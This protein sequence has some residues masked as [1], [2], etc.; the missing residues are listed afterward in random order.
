MNAALDGLLA[1]KVVETRSY[2]Q[3][4]LGLVC[5]ELHTASGRIV[6]VRSKDVPT[7]SFEAYTLEAA[8]GIC[9]GKDLDPN[10]SHRSACDLEVDR[11]EIFRRDEWRNTEAPIDPTVGSD[12]V[13]IDAGPIG[14]APSEAEPCTVVSGLALHPRDGSQP[15][16]LVYLSD[17]PGLITIS[18]D[19]SDVVGYRK[20]TTSETVGAR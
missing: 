12:P 13:A 15:L 7:C 11:I 5:V 17:Y 9:T 10:A 19:E 16:L 20:M 2:R 6:S 4:H 14:S 1:G 8:D 3:A 18:T